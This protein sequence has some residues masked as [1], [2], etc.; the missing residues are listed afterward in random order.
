MSQPPDIHITAVPQF[1]GVQGD[2]YAFA[3][4]ITIENRSGTTVTLE[5]RHWV[6]THGDGHSEEVRG[7][8]VVG[9]FPRLDPGQRYS[10][11]SGAMLPTPSGSMQ[12]S[13]GFVCE[14]GSR[15]RA[16]IDEFALHAPQALH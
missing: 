10:Y 4:T 3:Y 7:P 6:I 15:F 13:Y 16:P 11:S 1:F 14:N 8:G 9:E 2:H 5:D 12:G